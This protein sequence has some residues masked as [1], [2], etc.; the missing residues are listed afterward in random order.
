MYHLSISNKKILKNL[1]NSPGIYQYFDSSKKILYVGKAKNLKNRIPS[2]FSDIP[3]DPKTSRL[4]S[5]I[6]F[7]KYI[8]VRNEIEAFLLE[9]ALIKQYKP[10]YN[11]DL[12]D[13]KSYQFVEVKSEKIK[14]FNENIHKL[15]IT[16]VPK[17]SKPN[18]NLL[19]PYVDS[20]SLKE[21]IKILRKI[22]PHRTCSKS[23]LMLQNKQNRPCIYG[24]IKLC[25]A[26][27]VNK[28]GI[29]INK[30]NIQNIVKLLKK[31]Y[32][33]YVAELQRN[34]TQSAKEQKYEQALE[35]RMLIEKFESLA[36]YSIQPI[37]Y[38][39]NPNLLED[40]ADKRV[41]LIREIFNHYSFLT[42]SKFRIE[43]YDISNIMGE[44]A[45][46]SMVV[47][48]NGQLKLS[49]YRRFRIKYTKGITDVGMMREVIKR[50]SKHK[51]WNT[52]D[53]IML[54]GGKTQFNTILKLF[55]ENKITKTFTDSILL[56]SMFKPNDYLI[57]RHNNNLQIIKPDRNNEGFLHLRSLRDE[58]H[59]FAK[60]YHQK[61]RKLV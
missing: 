17:S 8:E 30:T 36:K 15:Q 44:W 9:S 40:V 46:G 61:L 18:K 23:R 5:K 6:R 51:E 10:K 35:Y 29:E 20:G 56:S 39:D 28:E 19:G 52:P 13:D 31:G 57:V 4:V 7:L 33:P 55:S 54:D 58:A 24:Q 25:P 1:P 32:S 11:I 38:I 14:S 16:R 21:V 41:K 47:S 49:E 27:C 60:T 22:Y 48:E 34:M 59:R 37:E 45:T 2:Y 42:N 12:K 3:K 43:C 53:I 50:R 26:P